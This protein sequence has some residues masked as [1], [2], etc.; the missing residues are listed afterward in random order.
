[1]PTQLAIDHGLTG[2]L[3]SAAAAYLLGSIPFGLIVTQMAGLGDIR[4]IGSGNIGTTNVL[5]T[6]RKGLAALTLL[7]DAG[8]GT[9]AVLLA[10]Y[11]L[12]AIDVDLDG[13]IAAADGN[14]EFADIS[15]SISAAMVAALFAVLGHM[16]PV[17]LRFRGGKGVATGLG[18][19]LALSPLVG[20]ASLVVWLLGALI[21]RYSSVGALITFLAA[22]FLFYL[23]GPAVAAPMAVVVMVLVWVRHHQNIRR[24]I[25]GQESRIRLFSRE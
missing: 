23:L 1:M 24:L 2:L 16:F 10:A 9:A 22:P 5:R 17:W 15:L 12:Y 20:F 7:L 6:G 21:S 14:V 13:A 8:K 25:R 19:Y 18:C 3:I 4:T 11:L